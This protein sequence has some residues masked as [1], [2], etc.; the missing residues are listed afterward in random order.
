MTPADLA[1]AGQAEKLSLASGGTAEMTPADLAEAG[2][3]SCS[4]PMP[5]RAPTTN[6]GHDQPVRGSDQ[7]I[8]CLENGDFSVTHGPA[9][10]P[11]GKIING[12]VV[13]EAPRPLK[14]LRR[15]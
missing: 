7:P 10:S 9:E 11:Q 14:W 2:Q 6:S 13:G 8:E 15:G 12:F 1:E 5:A 4:L 3:W